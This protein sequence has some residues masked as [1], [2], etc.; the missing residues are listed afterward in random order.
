MCDSAESNFNYIHVQNKKRFEI[1]RRLN[2]QPIRVPHHKPSLQSFHE[3]PS[4]ASKFN[5][6]HPLKCLHHLIPS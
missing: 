5:L 6:T 4:A 3:L 1:R 2:N